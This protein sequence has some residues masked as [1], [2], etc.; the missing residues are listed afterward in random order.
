LLGDKPI[1]AVTRD[2]A[3]CYRDHRLASGVSA[4]TVRREINVIRAVCAKAILELSLGIPNQFSSLDIT[5]QDEDVEGKDRISYSEEEIV[6]LV[7]EA[8]RMNDEQRRIV[9]VLAFT[10][11][12]L[13]EIVGL[14]KDDFDQARM[15][16]QIRWSSSRSLK[17][18]YSRREVPLLPPAY[19][20]LLE[21]ANSTEGEFLFPAYSSDSGTKA[22]VAS[23]TLNKWASRYVKG[24]SMHCFRHAYRD[25]MRAVMCPETIAKEIGGWSGQSDVSSQYGQGHPL[26]MKVR[27]L[28]QAYQGILSKLG[29]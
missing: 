8:T 24:K 13:A 29:Y 26:E 25:R 16:A 3:K 5:A 18:K 15:C 11:A 10:G 17:T 14:R 12:R 20:A 2:D 6:S 28:E 27:W 9:I 4:S 21:Q 23:A 1:T 22:N 19:K 7:S